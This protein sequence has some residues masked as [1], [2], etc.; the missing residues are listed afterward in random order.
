VTVG[1]SQNPLTRANVDSL[2]EY[3]QVKRRTTHSR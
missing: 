3:P 1:R 2:R